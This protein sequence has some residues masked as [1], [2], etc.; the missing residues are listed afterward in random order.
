MEAPFPTHGVLPGQV[1][2]RF[3]WKSSDGK[4]YALPC[5]PNN[6]REAYNI[7]HNI[8]ADMADNLIS[9]DEANQKIQKDWRLHRIGAGRID[10]EF[11]M[12]LAEIRAA[13]GELKAPWPISQEE[14]H[15]R[16]SIINQA[17]LKT[18]PQTMR[19]FHGR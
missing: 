7:L 14:N 16:E 17:I 18:M 4:T 10:N 6:S 3:C 12:Y 2:T 11:A 13:T 1:L 8:L 15:A 19:P 5:N 9:T